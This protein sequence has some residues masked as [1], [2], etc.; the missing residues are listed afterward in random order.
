M[1]LLIY[2]SSL[3]I[4]FIVVMV[5]LYGC[6]EK[7]DIYNCFTKGAQEGIRTV[8]GILPVLIG[9]ITAVTVL[10]ESRLIDMFCEGVKP[11]ADILN[12]PTK[13]IPLGFMKMISSSGATGFLT[14][15]FNTEGPDSF[16]GRVS[17][18]MMCSTETIIYTM[19]VYFAGREIKDTKYILK[20]GIVANLAG[21][22]GSFIVVSK[23]FYS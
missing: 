5:V 8:I 17:S 7:V 13:I 2:I 14:D 4:P 1:N 21:M 16:V 6:L 18:V 10:R 11:V 19:S 22:V 3:I 12:I 23:I 9:L 20:G 15:I